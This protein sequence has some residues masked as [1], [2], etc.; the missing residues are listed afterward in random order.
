MVLRV[1]FQTWIIDAFNKRM[2]LQKS[3]NLHGVRL[4]SLHSASQR[5]YASQH[6][7]GVERRTCQAQCVADPRNLFS[8]GFRFRNDAATDHVRMTVD[9]LGGRMHNDVDTK[10]QRTLQVRRQKRIV[11]N[12]DCVVLLRQLGYCGEVDNFQQWI[13]GSFNPD[14]FGG[15][16]ERSF[17][18]FNSRHIDE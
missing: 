13:A 17:D 9:V 2:T 5:F 12:R 10:V 4:L 3:S 14:T 11:S 7:P 15:R 8:V 16:S 1:R 6:Q 18:V